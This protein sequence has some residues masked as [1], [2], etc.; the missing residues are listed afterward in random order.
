MIRTETLSG[1]VEGIEEGD[2]TAFKGVPYA[3]APVDGLRLRAPKPVASWTGVRSAR[4]YGHWAPQNPPLVR[5]SGDFPGEQSEDCLTLNVWTPGLV[6]SRP[7][8]VWVHGG[9]FVGGSGASN[10]YRGDRLASRGD[11][12]VVTCN[13]RLG[14]LG[15]AG[16]RSLV[17]TE[18]DGTTG[19]WGLLDQ[20]AVLRWVNENI[21]AFGGDP[22]NVTI[23]G[24]SAGGMSVADLLAVPAAQGLFAR[25]IVQSGPPT[26]RLMAQAED[27]VG[28]LSAELGVAVGDLRHVP[29]PALLSVQA[30]ILTQARGWPLPFT[31][32]VDGAALPAHPQQ[33]LVDGTAAR[34][35]LLIG[36]NKDE[37]KFFLVADPKGRDPDEEVVRR[38][39]ERGFAATDEQLTP[40]AA[41]DAYRAIRAG[42][43]ESVEPRDLWSAIES[44]RVF[45]VNSIRAAEAHAVHQAQTY[46]YLFTWESPAMRGAL[47][48]CHALELPFVFGTLD[49]PEIDRFTGAGPA[50]AALSGQL[51]DTWVRFARTGDP[52]WPPYDATARTTMLF[53]PETGV[54]HAPM[55]EERAVW[56]DG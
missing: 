42:R 52:G 21:E 6:G 51:M 49:L 8:L 1:S 47:G 48:S 31:P 11:V 7:V 40:E 53:G 44:D 4:N 13:Y 23:F 32:V 9:A 43:G 15:F 12:V 46:S 18:A 36:T 20:V 50:A 45:R 14:I 19:N 26:A 38:R 30:S 33:S 16:H 34:V 17:D 22:H 41:I 29:I 5:L 35:P 56:G 39:L 3:R 24:E 37:F 28:K 25:A 2:V 55:N 27:V 10:M 54:E